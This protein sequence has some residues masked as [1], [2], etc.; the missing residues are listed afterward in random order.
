MKQVFIV[1]H[2]GPDKLQLRESP[3][4]RPARDEIR[5]K[6]VRVR[7]Q[8]ALS[9]PKADFA[10]TRELLNPKVHKLP[11]NAKLLGQLAVVYALLGDRQLAISEAK[12]ARREIERQIDW[13]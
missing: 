4:P 13:S 12:R 6:A 11:A 3:D 5:L 8:G 7:L 10:E 1:G 2:G 9:G